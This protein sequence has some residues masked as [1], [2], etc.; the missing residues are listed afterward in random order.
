VILGGSRGGGSMTQAR[1]AG[2]AGARRVAG[3]CRLRDVG[4]LGVR[5]LHAGLAMWRLGKWD[6][7]APALPPPAAATAAPAAPPHSGRT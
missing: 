2:L 6:A 5:R 4:K 7:L 1:A 3:S